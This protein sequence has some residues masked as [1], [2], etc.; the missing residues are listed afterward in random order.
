MTGSE[1]PGAGPQ[2]KPLPCVAVVMGTVGYKH[3]YAIPAYP[4]RARFVQI[5]WASEVDFPCLSN[6]MQRAKQPQ[7]LLAGACTPTGAACSSALLGW[8]SPAGSICSASL[9]ATQVMTPHLQS[10]PGYGAVCYSIQKAPC[11]LSVPWLT[12]AAQRTTAKG[13]SAP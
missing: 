12:P 13:C 2:Q 5:C 10:Q 3:N 6:F 8:I 11:M 9:Q 4:G 1:E 7:Q